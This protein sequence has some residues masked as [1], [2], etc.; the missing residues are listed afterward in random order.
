MPCLTLPLASRF[1]R[2]AVHVLGA[3]LLTGAAGAQ[4]TSYT[5][6]VGTLVLDSRH[7][8]FYSYYSE[9]P[10]RRVLPSVYAYN[11]QNQFKASTQDATIALGEVHSVEWL[12]S[13]THATTLS[14]NANGVAFGVAPLSASLMQGSSLVATLTPKAST[15]WWGTAYAFPTT[16]LAA[17]TEYRL[18]VITSGPTSLTNGAVPG[19]F[20]TLDVGV[21]APLPNPVPEP[22]SAVLMLAGLLGLPLLARRRRAP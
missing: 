9:T 15:S 12:F 22:A 6:D 3:A 4:A 8:Q 17:N 18:V 21:A 10:D 13:V 2:R 1:K 5:L 20:I 16:T 19:D 7:N 14:E 11:E